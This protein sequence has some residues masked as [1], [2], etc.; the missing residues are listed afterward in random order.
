MKKEEESYFAI[1]HH[2]RLGV[3][4]RVLGNVIVLVMR[5]VIILSEIE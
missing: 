1:G 4:G 2:I 3:V 5:E